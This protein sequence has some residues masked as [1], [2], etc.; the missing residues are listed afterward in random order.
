[1]NDESSAIEHAVSQSDPPPCDGWFLKSYDGDRKKKA[2]LE[3]VKTA[4]VISG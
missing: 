3:V 1:M 2:H 4:L